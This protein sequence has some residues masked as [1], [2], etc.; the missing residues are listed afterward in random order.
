MALNPAKVEDLKDVLKLDLASFVLDM[1]GIVDPTGAADVASGAISLWRG[2]WLSA[3]ISFLAFSRAWA[4][5]QRSETS[6]N[7][8]T[9]WKKPSN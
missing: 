1:V 8:S 9:R 6:G 3:G 7:T 4:I 2:D 5:S